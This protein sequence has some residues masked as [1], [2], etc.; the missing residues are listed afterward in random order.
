MASNNSDREAAAKQIMGIENWTQNSKARV[1]QLFDA[2]GDIEIS[3]RL[4]M[5]ENIPLLGKAL[6]DSTAAVNNLN[7]DIVKENAQSKRRVDDLRDQQMAALKEELKK[8]DLTP[9]QRIQIHEKMDKV[10]K[11]SERHHAEHQE[12]QEKVGEQRQYMQLVMT[13]VVGAAY[14]G[15]KIVPKILTRK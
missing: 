13:A 7:A 6:H 8:G 15:V 4:K 11:D 12:R 2:F 5:V 3:Q 14:A 9:E 10:V 1:M